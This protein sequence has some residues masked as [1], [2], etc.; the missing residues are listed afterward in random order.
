M[1]A[2]YCLFWRIDLIDCL[3]THILGWSAVRTQ[4]ILLLFQDKWGEKSDVACWLSLIITFDWHRHGNSHPQIQQSAGIFYFSICKRSLHLRMQR[5]VHANGPKSDFWL[6][7]I[8]SVAPLSLWCLLRASCLNLNYHQNVNHS[9]DWQL[10]CSPGP[11][12]HMCNG[13]PG[14]KTK[15]N[16]GTMVWQSPE[17]EETLKSFIPEIDSIRSFHCGGPSALNAATGSIQSDLYLLLLCTGGLTFGDF[18][19]LQSCC[20]VC[21]EREEGGELVEWDL[22]SSVWPSG[23]FKSSIWNPTWVPSSN[24]FWCHVTAVQKLHN[25]LPEP[26]DPFNI[27]LQVK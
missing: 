24:G 12:E 11:S 4:G 20:L 10:C 3:V 26:P 16:S 25:C 23:L 1:R 21:W 19:S 2:L 27:Q 13:I 5:E 6:V 9:H 14:H 7:S 18:I 8:L 17:A 15:V 22:L